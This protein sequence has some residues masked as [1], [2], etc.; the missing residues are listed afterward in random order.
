M[1]DELLQS[2]SIRVSEVWT[3]SVLELPLRAI[4]QA[5]GQATGFFDQALMVIGAAALTVIGSS[6]YAL[7][8]FARRR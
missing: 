4:K 1:F 6:A 5:D 3:R 7:F 2:R 8:W